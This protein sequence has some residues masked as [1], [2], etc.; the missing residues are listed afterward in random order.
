MRLTIFN[1]SPKHGKNN[2]DMM[3]GKLIEGFL[4]QGENSVEIH[5]LNKLPSVEA[6]AEIFSKAESVLVAMPLYCY[7][8]PGGV[9]KFFE[10][11]KPL[12]GACAGKK[13]AFLIQFGF[14]EAIHARPLEKY[15]EKLSRRLGCHYLGTI[16]KGGCDNLANGPEARYAD[17]FKGIVDIGATLG[18]TGEFNQIELDTF[19]QPEMLEKQPETQTEAAME[20]INK[21]YWGAMLEKNGVSLEASYAKPLL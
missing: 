10:A 12:T 20:S 11:L 9:M 8:M 1:G 15:L 7:A 13:L 19:S 16:I 3:L 18:R 21:R 5:K 4:S 6:A 17:L 14:P 2:T